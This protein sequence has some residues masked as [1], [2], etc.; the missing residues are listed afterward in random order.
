MER[1][2]EWIQNPFY[3][4]WNHQDPIINATQIL[5]SAALLMVLLKFGIL[6]AIL[7]SYLAYKF[8]QLISK[9]RGRTYASSW[10]Y[11]VKI[12]DPLYRYT[13]IQS[14]SMEKMKE[15]FEKNGENI[16]DEGIFL[17]R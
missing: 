8:N 2:I 14:L 11:L 1:I 4:D 9:I 3:A 10:H 13:K 12:Q 17:E 15:L 7:V 5:V 16:T 6:P